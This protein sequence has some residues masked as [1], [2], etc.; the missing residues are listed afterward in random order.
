MTNLKHDA[1]FTVSLDG[2]GLTED[3]I[4]S[5]DKKIKEVVMHELAQIDNHGDMVVNARLAVNPRLKGW[6]WVNR[7]MGIWI[8]DYSRYLERIGQ[9]PL[10]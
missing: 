6:E 5:L 10:K 4:L 8:E 3:Q 2:I 7:T 1:I 9:G